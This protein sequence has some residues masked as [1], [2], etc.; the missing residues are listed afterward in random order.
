[1][2]LT[3]ISSPKHC[4][5]Q[6]QLSSK[7]KL[8]HV[9]SCLKTVKSKFFNLLGHFSHWGPYLPFWLHVLPCPMLCCCLVA[10]LYPILLWPHGLQSAR[11]ICPWDFP[12]KN[13][14]VGSHLLLQGILPT[15]GLNES[16]FPMSAWGFFTTEPPGKPRHKTYPTTKHHH[17]TQ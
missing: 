6:C 8:D 2:S 9:I 5:H 10:K 17:A 14:G 4:A 3:L 16:L 15:Q 13:T 7:N 11:L 12:G 1:M